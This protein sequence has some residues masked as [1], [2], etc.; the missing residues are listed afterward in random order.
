MSAR[1]TAEDGPYPLPEGWRWVKLGDVAEIVRNS[2]KPEDMIGDE[3]YL[4]LDCI[5]SGGEIVRWTTTSAEGVT[6]NKF[7][8]TADHV[9]MGKLRPYLGKI[10]APD[11]DGV[12]STDIIPLAPGSNIAREYLLH[13]LRTDEMVQEA[14]K[15][16]SGANLPRISPN[17][18]SD[19]NVPLPPLCQQK[20]ISGV[21][22]CV[23]AIGNF[24]RRQIDLLDRLVSEM[25]NARFGREGGSLSL[26]DVA[27]LVG[28]KSIVSKN[29][30]I[31]SPYKV[32]KISSVTS[33]VFDEREAKQ[34]P[35]DYVPPESHLV[36]KGDLLMSRANTAELVG[37][38]AYV[39]LEVEG[40]T[41]PD[42]VWKF[43]WK[44]PGQNPIFY[45]SLLSSHTVRSRISRMSSGSGGSMKN[46]PKA[47]LLSLT[48]PDVSPADQEEYA[49]TVDYIQQIRREAVRRLDQ[50]DSLARSL[51]YRAFRGEL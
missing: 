17:A 49:R 30:A 47:K 41:L 48:I 35:L 13:W 31:N 46:I 50:I 23:G 14:N 4:G 1:K 39:D 51:Q 20:R 33:G 40:L 11:R 44:R 21:L 36:K 42:K 5:A 25:F 29:Q 10:A 26:G 18:I 9:L 19:L 6:S 8:F 32:L 15:V 34:L 12:C 38:S 7:S 28:G 2:V 16:S 45:Q 3:P 22:E 43:A 24:Q 37:A 27:S